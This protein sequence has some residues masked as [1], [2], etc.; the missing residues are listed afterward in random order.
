[1]S[2]KTNEII[3]DL[4][5]ENKMTQ[6]ELGTL[7]NC[8]RYRIADIERGKSNPTIEDIK[9]LS[10]NFNISSDYL[11]GISDVKTSNADIKYIND[12]IGLNETVVEWL[13]T[14]NTYKIGDCINIPVEDDKEVIGKILS[15]IDMPVYIINLI[16]CNPKLQG[17][18]YS[19]FT[20]PKHQNSNVYTGDIAN[21]VLFEIMILLRKI[22][23]VY[24][25]EYQKVIDEFEKSL[26]GE[27]ANGNN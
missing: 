19:Y 25:D 22:R 6:T 1:M 5:K 17:L 4:R 20:L 3:K 16:L 2:K 15:E 27:G 12:Y 21:S 9:I 10:K 13:S 8:D 7:L 26:N 23:N 18:F 14:V 24:Q 11:L